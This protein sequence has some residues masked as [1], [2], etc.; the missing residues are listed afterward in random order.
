MN[1]EHKPYGVYEKFL[2]RLCDIFC[3]MAAILVFWWLYLIVAVLV[4]VKLGGPVLFTQYRPGKN[5]KIFKM[6]KFRT[7]TNERD[8]NG[9]LL[10]DEQRLTRFGEFLR[11]TSLDELPEVFNILK[12]DMS[13]V[14]PR[15]QLVRDM[16]FM[17]EKERM[18]HSVRP[19]LSGLAQISG[20]NGISW[21]QKL[22]WDLVYIEKITFFNDLKII[23]WT[24]VNALIKQDGITEENS[25]TATDFGDYLLSQARISQEEYERTQAAAAGLLNG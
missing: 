20:R 17:S 8:E 13:V 10:P 3:G 14:G 16:I 12:G 19:G 22:S 15:P 24:V 11:K 25:A 23:F 7:M 2:K 1:M 18:R 9:A 6:Y 5:E 21:E 4:R